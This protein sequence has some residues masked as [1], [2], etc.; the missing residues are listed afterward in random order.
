[1]TSDRSNINDRKVQD[2]LPSQALHTALS[3]VMDAWYAQSQAAASQ[4]APLLK[5]GQILQI[6]KIDERA[7]L[8]GAIQGA[9]QNEYLDVPLVIAG[10]QSALKSELGDSPYGLQ[11][12]VNDATGIV[13]VGTTDSRIEN[14]KIAIQHFEFDMHPEA[15]R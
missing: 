6:G 14:G 9:F 12:A 3:E 10:V 13:T 4:I 8:E 15:G 2:E 11:M 5:D 7:V 1:M